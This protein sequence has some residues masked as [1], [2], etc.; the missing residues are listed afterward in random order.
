MKRLIGAAAT[1][2]TFVVGYLL[3][4]QVVAPA[5]KNMAETFQFSGWE[6]WGTAV[7]WLVMAGLVVGLAWL[8][9]VW[10]AG[11]RVAAA[12]VAVI[13][14]AVWAVVPLSYS[15]STAPMVAFLPNSVLEAFT[16]PVGYDSATGGFVFVLGV[17]ALVRARR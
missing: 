6:M 5:R 4:W 1:G 10:V 3:D 14:L 12:I 11:D 13:G 15:P 16:G 7:G 8:L 17:T 2:A 9:F